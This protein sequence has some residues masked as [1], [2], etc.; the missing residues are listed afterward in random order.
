MKKYEQGMV[1]AQSLFAYV[2][3]L[4]IILLSLDIFQTI[5]HT[6]VNQTRSVEAHKVLKRETLLWQTEK[7]IS[8]SV[9]HSPFRMEVYVKN[10]TVCVL[11]L[12][13]YKKQ[14]QI[15]NCENS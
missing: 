14:K 7:N 15:C 3:I 5:T 6:V 2:M 8:S 4:F 10:G 11:Y 13:V 12:D 1:L 9:I